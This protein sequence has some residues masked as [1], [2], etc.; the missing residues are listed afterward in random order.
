MTSNGASQFEIAS[1]G[2]VPAGAA[3]LLP[4]GRLA[5]ERQAD[6][7]P[8][9]RASRSTAACLRST[10]ATSRASTRPRRI[11]SRRRRRPTTR[12]APIPEIPV[13]D[14][15]VLGGLLF[16]DGPVND[17][18]IEA[19]AAR[20]GRRTRSTEKTV[21]RGGV[22]LFSYDYFFENINQ[23]GFSQATPILTSQRQRHHVHR[24]EPD[25]S[26][27]E[28]PAHAAGRLG[29]RPAEPAR[30]EP[31]A[32]SISRT[33]R[34]RT[35][36][37]GRSACSAISVSGFVAAATYLGSRGSNLPVV[38]SANNIPIQYLSTSR[39]RDTANETFLTQDGDESVHRSARR[40]ARS[41]A[42]RCSG[43]S[44]CGRSRSSGRSRSRST[45]AP[46]ATTPLTLQLDK[47]FRSGNSFTMQYTHSS[48]RDKLN[49]LNPADGQLEDRV[50]PNDRPNRFSIGGSVRLPFGTRREVGTRVERRDGCRARAAGR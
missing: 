12:K 32:R 24:R 18:K 35:T 46:I 17:T 19:A 1:P 50:S 25:Q 30:S 44:S 28:R 10:T 48:L 11:R 6:R 33:A 49:Y 38:Q 8:R 27:S 29:A 22:G 13:A 15:H 9:R 45:R 40:A 23:A 3:R 21:V 34:R 31:R 20:R 41:T 16:A 36:R 5:R 26:A 42:R 43:C 7:Q 37:A 2:I 47:R 4:A 14:F 39:T